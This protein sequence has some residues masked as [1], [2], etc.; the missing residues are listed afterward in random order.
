MAVTTATLIA[1]C[2]FR[3]ITVRPKENAT[4]VALLAIPLMANW[5]NMCVHQ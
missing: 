2:L 3:G 4:H 1:A 5:V